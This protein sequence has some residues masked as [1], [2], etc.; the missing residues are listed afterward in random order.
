GAAGFIGRHTV[1]T[2][3]ARGCNV[4][5]IVR[6]GRAV[7]NDWHASDMI[8]VHEIDLT[9]PH[10]K[11]KLSCVIG[12]CRSVIHAAAS[13]RGDDAIQNS[14]TL[15]ANDN[16]LEAYADTDAPYPTLVLVSSL[17][18][19]DTSSLSENAVVSEQTPLAGSATDR[20]AYCRAK[21]A[22]EAAVLR[23]AAQLD[24]QV[25]IMRPGTVFG[26]GNLWNDHIGPAAGPVAVQLAR[27]GEIPTCYVEHCA[28][29]LVL[30][31]TTPVTRDDRLD[32]SDEGRVEFI[33]I[34]DDDRP[35]R[36]DYLV[37]MRKTGWPKVVVPGTWRALAAGGKLLKAIGLDQK[38]PGLLRP[39]VLHARIKPL[40]YC[41]HRLHDRLSWQAT[42]TFSEAMRRSIAM[43]T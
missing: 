23:A 21:L 14:T 31:A 43:E 35:T 3:V 41:N 29:V 39:A 36:D 10:D 33:N 1:D 30:A 42:A 5:A 38:A 19:Y 2:A 7:P 12:E 15:L 6:P 4:A 32:A 24:L 8:T 40:R 20:D 13:L 34:V 25:R 22:Q 28:D 11:T 9:S 37:E 26:S 27:K 18:V 16:L 17:A